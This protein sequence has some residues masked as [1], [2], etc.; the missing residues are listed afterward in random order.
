MKVVRMTKNAKRAFRNGRVLGYL[1]PYQTR[2]ECQW[3]ASFLETYMP[4]YWLT[5]NIQVALERILNQ[6]L[7][8]YIDEIER[9]AAITKNEME[10]E[11]ESVPIEFGM[12]SKDLVTCGETSWSVFGVS[13]RI[14]PFMLNN[15]FFWL[16][17]AYH[18]KWVPDESGTGHLA[19]A[20]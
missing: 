16:R 10:L 19:R 8:Q 18:C 4:K 9:V 14:I 6:L 15:P 7:Q 5:L 17:P 20:L 12:A 13:W 2:T 1:R 3:G 11:S